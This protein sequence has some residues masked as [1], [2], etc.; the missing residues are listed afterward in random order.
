MANERINITIGAKDKA[1]SVFRK[2][3]ST[4]GSVGKSIFNFKTALVGAA[5]VAGIG[6]LVKQSLDATDR[7]AKLSRTIGLSVPE[8]QALQ[9]AGKLAGVELETI[10]KSV[11]NLS[12]VSFDLTRGL[13]TNKDAFD[14]LGISVADVRKLQNDQLGLFELVGDR[15]S[16]LD[17][18]FEKTAIAQQ[19]FGGR[20]SEVIRVLESG[21]GSFADLRKEAGGL[22]LILSTDAAAGVEAAND[23]FTRLQS[24]FG[25]VITQITAALAPALE[26]I[27]NTMTDKVNKAITEG[28]GS[29]ADFGQ[30][31]VTSFLEGIK[32]ALVALQLFAGEARLFLDRFG[33]EIPPLDVSGAVASIQVLQNT[34]KAGS[35]GVRDAII[36]NTQ[37]ANEGIGELAGESRTLA[38][39][40]RENFGFLEQTA[41]QSLQKNFEDI[42]NGTKNSLQGLRD[43]SKTI[44]QAIISEFI[45]LQVVQPIISGIFSGGATP[46]TAGGAPVTAGGGNAIG[47]S[48]QRGRVS[49]VGERGPELFVPH[50]AGSIVPNNAMGGGGV[51]VNQTINVTT[52]VQQTVRNEIQTMMP[53][54]QAASK[55]AVLDASRRGGSYANS[56]KR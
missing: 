51:T 11:R 45:K 55:Q 56:M 42:A 35:E 54:I 13:E 24:L 15:L 47:G 10:G 53:Q 33:V 28:G 8:L 40:F 39:A 27:A 46:A 37:D 20:A 26:L 22:G 2:F 4:L 25:G 49:L 31:I 18:G 1:T 36:K 48:V 12:R 16:Q 44:V 17:D 34:I 19:L 5:G 43:F 41:E 21:K 30:N 29:V 38:E 32:K 9:F 6:V 3:Q 23:A 50:S 14:T 52:G 7:L